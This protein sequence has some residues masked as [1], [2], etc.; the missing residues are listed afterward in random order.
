[1]GARRNVGLGIQQAECQARPLSLC[2]NPLSIVH[3][4]MLT[5]SAKRSGCNVEMYAPPG[6]ILFPAPPYSAKETAHA[7]IDRYL[8]SN[9]RRS[10]AHVVPRCGILSHF[11]PVKRLN[12]P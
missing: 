12:N 11:T 7:C 6:Y 5:A 4:D 1:M 9:P 10:G 3:F 8:P 2:K